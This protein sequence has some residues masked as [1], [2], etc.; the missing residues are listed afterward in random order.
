ME[1]Y[2][3]ELS[4]FGNL[5]RM[6]P[7][8]L[9]DQE[10]L[11]LD[12]ILHR[13][14]KHKRDGGQVRFGNKSWSFEDLIN[15]HALVRKEMSRRAFQHT[16]KDELDDQTQPFLK[17]AEE[18]APVYPSGIQL[19]REITLGEVLSQIKSFYAH[20]IFAWIVGGLA[21]WGK[22]KGDIDILWWAT[23]AIPEYF[24]KILEFRFG[25][26]FKDGE[27]A[28]RVQHHLNFF[29]GPFTKAVP[30]YAL[31][32]ERINS[33]GE[34]KAAGEGIVIKEAAVMP[35]PL[36]MV[37]DEAAK[38]W[39][40][41]QSWLSDKAASIA[42]DLRSASAEFIAQ[43]EAS[44]KE[45]AVKLFRFFIPLKPTK[46]HK[47]DEPQ[48]VDNFLK[49]FKDE[50]FPVYSS[51]KFDG[52]DY[53]IF[54]DADRVQ[55][56]SED[57]RDNTERFPQIVE[58]LKK[59]PVARFAIL[60]E[61]ERWDEDN[62]LPRETVTA[63]VNEA[64]EPDDSDFVANV[65]DV[66]FFESET[67]KPGDIHKLPFVDR[68]KY[69]GALGFPQSTDEP[70]DLDLKLNLVPHYPA[71]NKE[72]LK[73][74]TGRL[75]RLEGSEG[76]VAKAHRFIY[77]LENKPS[78]MVKFHNAAILKGIVTEVK[79]TKTPEVFNFF[80]GLDFEDVE[81]PQET[82]R[83]VKGKRYHEIGTTFSTALKAK[84]GDIVE[85]E[86]ETLNIS[87][88]L[89]K[90]T[91]AVTA[92]APRVLSVSSQGKPMTVSEA[93]ES[94]E[95]GLVLQ[96]KEITEDGE[97]IFKGV[98]QA[99]GSYG[100]KRFLAHRIA[101][102][103]PYHKTYIEPFAGGAAVFFAKDHSPNLDFRR[104]LIC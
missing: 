57:G 47:P 3:I 27:I 8:K 38:G 5:F 69:L 64:S 25:R 104:G 55:M 101:S 70:P 15:L 48:T 1:I 63:Y 79:E 77:N 103:I 65:Y 34:I 24:K 62:H 76:N 26:Q 68:L 98:R 94:A 61:V 49:F 11:S 90:G 13:A 88:D 72:E 81:V 50:D 66:V 80:Y 93:I 43:A 58:A 59:L 35:D 85:V 20:P 75:R 102:Y 51:K 10:L 22:T 41:P 97:T 67:A 95:K 39:T 71:G 33:E 36:E 87:R 16:I 23:P 86:F 96:E 21:N 6:D 74:E 44:A 14:W 18:L 89:Q 29:Q 17:A 4:D 2:K 52:A 60:S 45:D 56:I 82:I 12:F 40:I 19:G 31:K 32:V 30:I 53:V 84:K 7:A 46:G 54:R 78:G 83:D 42:D 73:K 100:G 99:F 91:I 28:G 37:W 9:S 92:W